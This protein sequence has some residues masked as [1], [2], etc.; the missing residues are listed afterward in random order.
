[1]N[2]HANARRLNSAFR[3]AGCR[4]RRGIV[5]LV[6]LGMLTLFSMLAV[7]YLVF[8]A[9]HRSAAR[10]MNSAESSQI[11]VGSL[12]D[13]ALFKALVGSNGPDSGLWGHDMLG[14]LYGMRDGIEGTLT[15]PSRYPDPGN[16][17][18]APEALLDGNFLRFPTELF[19]TSTPQYQSQYP[20]RRNDTIAERRYPRLANPAFPRDDSLTGRLLTFQDGPLEGLTMEIVRYFGDHTG[21]AN[22]RRG[23]SGQVVVDVRPHLQTQIELNGRTRTLEQWIDHAA[24][25]AFTIS[26]LFYDQPAT[27]ASMAQPLAGFYINGRILNGPGIGWDF[28][29]DATFTATGTAFNLN[30]VISTTLDIVTPAGVPRSGNNFSNPGGR[31][32]PVSMQGNYGLYRFEPNH[33][34]APAS[35]QDL[36]PGDVDEPFDSPTNHDLWLS[37]FPGDPELGRPTP[38]FVRPAL[39]NWIINQKGDMTDAMAPMPQNELTAIL[40]ALQRSTLRPLPVSGGGGGTGVLKLDYADFSGSN[41]ALGPA[42]L[43][44]F[45]IN[46][47]TVTGPE[48]LAIARALVGQDLDGDGVI[49]SWDVD[50]DGD[51]VVD[52]VWIDAGLPLNETA[53]GRLVKPM[54]AYKIEDLGGRVDINRAGNV[55]QAIN[56]IGIRMVGP[57]QQA[58]TTAT[59]ATSPVTDPTLYTEGDFPTGFGYGPAEIDVRPLFSPQY[60]NGNGPR[61]LMELRYNRFDYAPPPPPVVAPVNYYSPGEFFSLL[62]GSSNDLLGRFRYPARQN[63]FTPEDR[64]GLP[65]DPFGRTAVGLGV[66]GGLMV[67]QATF[68]VGNTGAS[69]GGPTGGQINDDPYELVFNAAD[70]P[71]SPLTYSDLEPVLRF[72]DYDRDLIGSRLLDLINEYHADPSAIPDQ[73]EAVRKLLA[74]SITTA[75]NSAATTVGHLPSEWRDDSNDSRSSPSPHHVFWESLTAAGSS[76]QE[77]AFMWQLLAPEIRAGNKFNLNRPLGN[78][79]NDDA[80]NVIDD[81]EEV[82]STV[83]NF[84]TGTR[85]QTTLRSDVTPGEP[86]RNSRELFARYLYFMALGLTRDVSVAPANEFPFPKNAPA[87]AGFVGIG[88]LT[89]DQ[90]YNAWKVAQWAVNVVDYRDADGIMTR[91]NYDPNPFDGWSVDPADATT[92]RTVWGM[93]YPELTLEESLAFHDRRQRDTADDTT[94]QQRLSGGSFQDDDPD[95]WR[96]PVGSLFLEVRST[97]SPQELLAAPTVAT[98]DLRATRWALPYELYKKVAHPLTGQEE[99]VLD[100]GLEAPDMNPVWRVAI[101]ELHNSPSAA[102]RPE[103]CPDFLF[104]PAGSIT[105]ADTE[106][107]GVNLNRETTVLDLN[108]PNFFDVPAGGRVVDRVIWFTSRDPD[109]A[110]RDGVVDIPV[111]TDSNE[112]GRIFYNRFTNA[113][114]ASVTTGG[115]YLR[116]GQFAVIGPRQLT[117]VGSLDEH[118][119]GGPTHDPNNVPLVNYTEYESNHRIS[120]QP[121]LTTHFNLNNTQTTPSVDLGGGTAGATIQAP[122]GIMAAANA[123]QNWGAGSRP[124]GVNISEPIPWATPNLLAVPPQ[125]YYPQPTESLHPTLGFPLDSYRDYENNQGQLPDTPFDSQSYAE[126]DRAYG[127]NGQQTGTRTHLKTAYLQRLADPTQPYHATNNPYIT[128]D[129]LALDLTV[130]N[131]SMINDQIADSSGTTEWRDESDQDPYNTAPTERFATRY[132]TGNHWDE[133]STG[134]QFANLVHSINTYPPEEH[135]RSAAITGGHIPYFDL[136][137]NLHASV[138]P[139][140]GG[141][142]DQYNAAIRP[143]HSSTLGYLNAT[144]GQ[145][146]AQGPTGSTSMARYVGLPFDDWGANVAWLNRDFVSPQELAWVP[147]SSPGRFAAEFGVASTASG[148]TATDPFDDSTNAMPNSLGRYDYN[149]QFSHLWNYLCSNPNDFTMSPN[150]WRLME[151]VEVPPPFDSEIDFLSPD[152]D[153]L[154]NPGEEPVFPGN[155]NYG[156]FGTPVTGNPETWLGG[157]AGTNAFW[158]NQVVTETLRPPFNFRFP[159]YRTGKI[160]LNT[161]KN[162]RVFNSLMFGFSTAGE[163]SSGNGAFWNDFT[164]SRRGYPNP[165]ADDQ[166]PHQLHPFFSAYSPTQQVGVF[167][168]AHASDIEP[169]FSPPD[170]ATTP[171]PPT[172][173]LRRTPIDSTRLRKGPTANRMLFRR[174]PAVAPILNSAAQSHERSVVHQQLGTSRLENLSS[175]Q[176]NVFAVWITVGLFEVDPST[177]RVGQEVGHDIGQT[178]RFRGFYIIDRS[179][180]VMYRPGEKNNTEGVVQLSRILN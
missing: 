34:T 175:N 46:P 81:P 116:G 76:A 74:D 12:L 19:R 140:L 64:Y 167:R 60:A 109:S 141:I 9:R 16:D 25:T 101:S 130:F 89:F 120:L 178:E 31:D 75:S 131:G 73:L 137:L 156:T 149:Q 66:G 51:G 22:A 121:G 168:T 18:I 26:E 20:N 176:S 166:G 144:F 169:E 70:E 23:L 142:P 27:A 132:K 154:L 7:S 126:L 83:E 146:W 42:N 174:D 117:H 40:R 107:G 1:M 96:I 125:R 15:L 148:L 72:N 133:D 32:M 21:A 170:G 171:A 77:N 84:F 103:L 57:V 119:T 88:G 163:R 127:V 97:R 44:N 78:G 114:Y 161:I 24:N 48:V 177:L 118:G 6:V 165:T 39:V 28:D 68:P 122:L 105:P 173:M 98:D 128:V 153:V 94:M 52:S 157:Q 134:A 2:S 92:Y 87:P 160:N 158:V 67:N 111:P 61:N 3:P 152:R 102:A 159:L 90:E 129:Y 37:Y 59:P 45:P 100:L 4:H 47:A 179:V 8:T 82:A 113:D 85:W 41:N 49:D 108:R 106:E 30:D 63:L 151:W 38:S 162:K 50:T 104:K 55:A 136:V 43:P 10:S 79:V 65:H 86:G 36:P 145:R 17:E 138:D 180:P 11:D 123:P 164:L 29:R 155:F 69:I 58:M 147:T 14:D 135:S 35:L 91:F 115:V 71:D 56:Q 13:E 53:D 99:F 93:E 172:P 150:F 5:L 80:D 143:Q 139:D 124:I 33:P 110:P 95:Q 54:V 112:V 62:T